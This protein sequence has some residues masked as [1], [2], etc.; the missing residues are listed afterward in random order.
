[1]RDNLIIEGVT[2]SPL[3]KYDQ[4]DVDAIAVATVD[5]A[6]SNLW[7]EQRQHRITASNIHEVKTKMVKHQQGK[8]TNMSRLLDKICGKSGNVCTG[9]MKYGLAMEPIARKAFEDKLKQDGHKNVK[10]SKC[11]LVVHSDHIYI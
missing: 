2:S 5:Q 1:M 11:G 9:D 6:K 4:S 10:V 3:P 8:Q 7:F